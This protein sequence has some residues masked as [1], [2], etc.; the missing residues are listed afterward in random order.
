VQEPPAVLLHEW[1]DGRGLVSHVDFT[2]RF[3]IGRFS[4]EHTR[5]R[6]AH[7]DASR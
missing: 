3:E 1:R 2:G 4:N 6:D 7:S 5:V